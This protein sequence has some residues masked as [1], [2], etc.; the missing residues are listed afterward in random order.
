MKV[1]CQQENLNRG[2]YITSHIVSKNI[3]LPILS[4]ILIRAEEKSLKLISTNLEIGIRCSLRGKVEEEGSVAIPAK[5]LNDY[6][7]LLPSE[8]LELEL[9][10]WDL[11]I[12]CQN[13][14]SSFKGSSPEDYPLLPTIERTFSCLCKNSGFKEALEQV[15]FSVLTDSSRPELNGILFSF[16]DNNRL[17]MVG[18]DS[19]RLAEKSITLERSNLENQKYIIPL[20]TLL[21]MTRIIKEGSDPLEMFL[22]NNQILF[23][24]KET[25]SLGE[26]VELISRLQGGQYP[27]YRAILPTHFDTQVITETAPLIK[28]VRASSIFSKL[29][30]YDIVLE[31]MSQ[32]NEIKVSSTNSQL[33]ENIVHLPS[34]V[35]GKDNSIILNYRYLLDGLTHI[36]SPEVVIEITNPESPCVLKPSLGEGQERDYLYIIMPIKQ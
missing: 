8:P 25:T 24:Y 27:D 21:E 4:N 18:T 7:A 32:K 11:K 13:Y 20:S 1:F 3:N 36:N 9:N 31:F 23:D 35:T 5:L 28:A 22:T 34:Q 30:I 19:Y 6:I 26:E 14:I 10:K 16:E 2:L 29:G 15:L 12:K 33:G 17:I